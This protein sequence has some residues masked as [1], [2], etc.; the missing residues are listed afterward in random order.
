MTLTIQ[1]DPDRIA[2]LAA[3][4]ARASGNEQS[5]I[6]RRIRQVLEVHPPAHAES[7]LASMERRAA[8][9][10]PDLQSPPDPTSQPQ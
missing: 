3:Q 10:A 6:E 4:F 9:V 1:I 2:R 8:T 7:I 5:G